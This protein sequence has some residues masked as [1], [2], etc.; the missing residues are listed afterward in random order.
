MTPLR[1]RLI[2]DLTLR[3]Y[4]ERTIQAYVA[5]VVR[6]T[7]FSRTAPDQLTEEQL[8]TY[9]LQFTRTHAAASVT[10]ALSSRTVGGYGGVSR[11]PS[12][13][14]TKAW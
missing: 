13:P 8:R 10:Q 1:Q 6:L 11:P 3:G 2:D 12:S 4:A 7:R 9:L 5:V 14:F